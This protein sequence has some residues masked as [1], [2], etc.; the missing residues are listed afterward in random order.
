M[1][2]T[3]PQSQRLAALVANQPRAIREQQH[4]KQ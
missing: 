1:I 4:Y 3:F 2:H